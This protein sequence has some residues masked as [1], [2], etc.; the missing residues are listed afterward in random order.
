MKKRGI[1]MPGYTADPTAKI[2]CFNVDSDGNLWCPYFYA[3]TKFG[4]T[5]SA[6]R[7]TPLDEKLPNEVSLRESQVKVVKS[8]FDDLMKYGTT[9]VGLPPGSGKTYI[10]SYLTHCLGLKVIVVVPRM[11]LVEQ[12]KTTFEKSIPGATI[13]AINAT[14]KLPYE[15]FKEPPDVIIALDP[16][17]PKIPREW[18][19]KMGTLIVDEAHML[20]TR[21]RIENL[22]SIRPKYIIMEEGM[23]FI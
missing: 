8:C 17:I 13:W 20:P 11:T 5:P 9:T 22:L 4:I 14:G 1:V 7:F 19:N 21:S 12:W 6:D 15:V 3:S 10:G 18:I 23:D 2:E 16:R